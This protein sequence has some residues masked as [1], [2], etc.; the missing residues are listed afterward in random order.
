MHLI[1]FRSITNIGFKFNVIFLCRAVNIIQ[2]KI[3]LF[4]E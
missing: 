2:S 4:K 3:K 1:W